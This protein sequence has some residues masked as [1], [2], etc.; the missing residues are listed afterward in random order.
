MQERI[1]VLNLIYE[2][3]KEYTQNR[4]GP[5]VMAMANAPHISEMTIDLPGLHVEIA[6]AASDPDLYLWTVKEHT[7]LP[8]A[9]CG[10]EQAPADAI[11]Q[12]AHA[13]ADALANE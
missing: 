1:D 3:A 6:R 11:Q 12:V 4:V 8:V 5:A 10:D 2:A 7:G 9:R 13:I